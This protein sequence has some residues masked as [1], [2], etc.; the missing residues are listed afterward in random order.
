[1]LADRLIDES[2]D[3]WERVRGAA[4]ELSP[5]ELK[6]LGPTPVRIFVSHGYGTPIEEI[7]QSEFDRRATS[8]PRIQVFRRGAAE[9]IWVLNDSDC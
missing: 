2:G 5:E 9:A 1:M 8:A 4:Y 3:P 6:R 7:T